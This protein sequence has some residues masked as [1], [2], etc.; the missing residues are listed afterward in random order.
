MLQQ[1]IQAVQ[2][3]IDNK[4]LEIT[5]KHQLAALQEREKKLT[6]EGKHLE[7]ERKYKEKI[8]KVENRIKEL[9]EE[10][11]YKPQYEEAQQ[12]VRGL[13]YELKEQ[14][15]RFK[16]EQ[17]EMEQKQRFADIQQQ[18]AQSAR[19][20]D[21][22]KQ[23]Q[24]KNEEL[25]G[26]KEKVEE[27]KD[28]NCQS[29]FE[30]QMTGQIKVLQNDLLREIHES[31]KYELDQTLKPVIEKWEAVNARV[32]RENDLHQ[33]VTN[34][35]NR[36]RDLEHQIALNVAKGS[37]AELIDDL[38]EQVDE[39][40]HKMEINELNRNYKRKKNRL[41]NE[42]AKLDIE[43]KTAQVVADVEDFCNPDTA[44]AEVE[45]NEAKH[46]SKLSVDM[47]NTQRESNK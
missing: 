21:F 7:K 40:R 33:L 29:S 32:Q 46:V 43:E 6:N 25:K 3:N 31:R 37:G 42:M 23:I 39:Q 41:G 9:E 34:Q 2:N 13:E 45:L 36:I 11:K 24:A 28:Y 16:R 5:Y 12:K 15:G 8:E 18:M 10:A 17:Q 1:R 38:Q 44:K 4:N 35:S 30:Q 14:E 26:M 19:E 27:L 22:Q 20:A 47:I